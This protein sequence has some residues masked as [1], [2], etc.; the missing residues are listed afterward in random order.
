MN[1]HNNDHT[2]E[3]SKANQDN[4]INS[5][6]ASVNQDADLIANTIA[7]ND[8]AATK[9]NPTPNTDEPKTNFQLDDNGEIILDK[10][11]KP[12]R[13]RGKP[14]G[15]KQKKQPTPGAKSS[16]GPIPGGGDD[17]QVSAADPGEAP[18]LAD[19]L[20]DSLDTGLSHTGK[21]LTDAEKS[22]M[23][24]YSGQIA[25]RRVNPILALVLIVLAIAAARA[26]WS[27]MDIGK[28]IGSPFKKKPG[29]PQPAATAKPS[30]HINTD[31][32]GDNEPLPPVKITNPTAPNVSI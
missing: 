21:K 32:P 31:S 10:K 12:K 29:K 7:S 11:G 18:S 23:K 24:K 13:R 1:I 16:V 28:I 8:D 17:D 22:N 9:H 25:T 27:K 3:N 6:P 30:T 20:V 15:T 2:T 14:Q 19:A 4:N 26:P 5:E